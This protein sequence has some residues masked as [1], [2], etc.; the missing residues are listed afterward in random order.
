MRVAAIVVT[1]NRKKLLIENIQA[2]LSQTNV[3]DMTIV[4]IDNNST[5]GTQD[6]LENYIKSEDIVYINTGENL[7]GAGGFHYGFKYAVE[8]NYDYIWAMDDDCIPEKNALEELVSHGNKLNDYGFL[9]S[10]V[11]WKD[12]TICKMNIQRES[13]WKNVSDWDKDIVPIIM[14]SFVSIFMPTS[15]VKKY[16]LPIKDFFIWTDDWEF[17]RRIS[18]NHKCYLIN[19]SVVVHKSKNNY[20]ASIVDDDVTRL[21]RYDFLYRNDVYLYRREKIQ[22][23]IYELLRLSKHIISVALY[24]KNNKLIRISKIIKGTIKGISFNPSI[25]YVGANNDK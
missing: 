8:N 20:G 5:D 16:G 4:V 18:I 2:L 21:S 10:K 9:A 15:K 12:N 17:T 3:N 7:G 14:T 6:E 13:L 23:I 24:S 1:Y 25:E 11:V 19:S 22:G